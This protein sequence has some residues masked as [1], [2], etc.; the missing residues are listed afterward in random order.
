MG[1]MRDHCLLGSG[2]PPLDTLTVIRYYPRKIQ[3]NKIVTKKYIRKP[4]IVDAVQVTTEN[5]VSIA[6]WCQGS[7]CDNE[8]NEVK[9]ETINPGSM[10]I[11]V[12]VHQPKTPRQTKAFVGD[13]ILYTDKGYKIYTPKAFHN[14]FNEAE[15][16]VWS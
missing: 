14:A 10:H 1:I 11:N 7:I 2:Y 6:L 3:M 5:F 12:R 9:A 16:A 15:E 4:L 8:D 13:W